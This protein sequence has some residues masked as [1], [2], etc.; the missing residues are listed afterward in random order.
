MSPNF[1]E[2]I[3]VWTSNVILIV[4]PEYRVR[5]GSLGLLG[6]QVVTAEMDVKES[7]VIWAAQGRLDLR[8]HQA[9][10]EL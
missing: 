4:T 5:T 9:Q 3:H 7:K 1:E 6:Y 2:T 10:Q 8:D